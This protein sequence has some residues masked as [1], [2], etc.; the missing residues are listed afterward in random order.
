VVRKLP[1]VSEGLT[2]ITSLYVIYPVMR[3]IQCLLPGIDSVYIIYLN[4]L[5]YACNVTYHIL[6]RVLK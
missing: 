6:N 2:D 4:V 5:Y 3:I 1:I